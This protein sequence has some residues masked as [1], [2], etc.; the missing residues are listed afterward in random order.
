MSNLNLRSDKLQTVCQCKCSQCHGLTP[1]RMYASFSGLMASSSPAPASVSATGW[2]ELP[3]APDFS[4]M[5]LFSGK[6]SEDSG[7]VSKL[8]IFDVEIKNI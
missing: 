5:K 6:L 1:M 7:E 8:K 4:E 2:A 3:P